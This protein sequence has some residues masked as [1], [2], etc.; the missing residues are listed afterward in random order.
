MVGTQV[1]EHTEHS[2]RRSEGAGPLTPCAAASQALSKAAGSL[3]QADPRWGLLGLGVPRIPRKGAIGPY[4]FSV[5]GGRVSA[6]LS[7]L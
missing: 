1:H 5:V 3:H 7:M 4:H 6:N 2:T